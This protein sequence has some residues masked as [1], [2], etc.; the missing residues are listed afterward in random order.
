MIAEMFH[1]FVQRGRRVQMSEVKCPVCSATTQVALSPE[2]GAPE[3]FACRCGSV[4]NSETGFVRRTIPVVSVPERQ[5]VLVSPFAGSRKL[6]T[7]PSD[8]AASTVAA[9]P[10]GMP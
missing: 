1:A 4:I 7:I 9:G 3:T 5:T 6:R 2:S 8:V 10:A